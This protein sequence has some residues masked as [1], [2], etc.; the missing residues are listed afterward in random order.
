MKPILELHNV[1]KQYK[2]GGAQQKYLSLRELPKNIFSRTEQEQFW[3]LNDISFN[4]SQG[5]S[6]GIIG[7][8]GAGK[9]TLLKILSKITPPTKG[10]IKVRGRVASLLEVGTGFHNELTGR[11]NIYLN[12]SLLGLKSAEINRK[13]G[14]SV[15]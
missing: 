1:S 6:I 15:V 9:S 2:I 13:F 12:G 8:N 5:E 10:L 14:K 11:E 4:I 7:P 3:A